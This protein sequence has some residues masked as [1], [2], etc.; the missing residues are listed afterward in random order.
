METPRNEECHKKEL[1]ENAIVLKKMRDLKSLSRRQ[2]GIICNLSHKTIEKLENG[3]GMLD[4]QRL[5]QFAE[6][7]GFSFEDLVRIRNGNF[8]TDI[9]TRNREKKEKDPFRRDRRFC[10]K[11]ITKE[12]KALRQLRQ[13]SGYSQYEA[14]EV[15]GY[16]RTTIGHIENG[17]IGLPEKRIRHIVGCLGFKFEDFQKVLNEDQ[18]HYELIDYC[19][20]IM[21]NLD[22]QKLKAVHSFLL[23]FAS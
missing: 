17:R 20:S 13:M 19:N 21:K 12:C 5:L 10:Q 6:Q 1:S 18:H 4:D 14:G 23:S 9:T 7:L 15:C 8:D 11:K 16:N 2:V 3:R 22:T